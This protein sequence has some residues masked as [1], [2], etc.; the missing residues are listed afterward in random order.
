MH[1]VSAFCNRTFILMLYM[2]GEFHRSPTS[3]CHVI[4]LK[5]IALW[6]K[7]IYRLKSIMSLASIQTPIPNASLTIV[8]TEKNWIKLNA[9]KYIGTTFVMSWNNHISELS[10]W[11]VLLNSQSSRIDAFLYD[12]FKECVITIDS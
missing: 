1:S 10:T 7:G 12:G 8:V 9:P 6:M 4:M 11:K 3:Q 2:F 5:I